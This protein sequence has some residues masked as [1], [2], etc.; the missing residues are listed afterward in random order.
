MW[1]ERVGFDKFNAIINAIVMNTQQREKKLLN[2]CIEGIVFI[3]V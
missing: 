1:Q 2:N 3:F